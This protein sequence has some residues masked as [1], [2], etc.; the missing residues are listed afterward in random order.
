MGPATGKGILRAPVR[1]PLAMPLFGCMV[2]GPM[3]ELG[4]AMPSREFISLRGFMPRIGMELLDSLRDETWFAVP[5]AVRE[6]PLAVMVRIG[7]LLTRG[8]ELLVDQ[9]GRL[10]RHGPVPPEALADGVVL[11][12]LRRWA[13]G[14]VREEFGIDLRAELCG[15]LHDPIRFPRSVL[16]VYRAN[17]PADQAPPVGAWLAP[18]AAR[19]VV[20][21]PLDAAVL[22]GLP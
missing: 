1:N 5:D 21:D 22:A 20:R 19:D 8:K 9:E 3:D 4:L 18:A 17:A 14:R 11:V 6:D 12:A 13:E 15:Y 16:L 10:I 7:L 2:T